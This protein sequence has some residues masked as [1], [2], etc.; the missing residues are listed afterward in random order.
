[1]NTFDVIFECHNCKGHTITFYERCSVCRID[2]RESFKFWA[3]TYHCPR[4]MAIEWIMVIQK[5]QPE[6]IVVEAQSRLTPIDSM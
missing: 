2:V 6:E 4:C 1:M 3:N 5:S